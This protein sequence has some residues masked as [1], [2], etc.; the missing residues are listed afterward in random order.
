MYPGEDYMKCFPK[1]LQKDMNLTTKT[2]TIIQNDK[3]TIYLKQ[4]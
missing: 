2:S 4:V 1:S 3:V